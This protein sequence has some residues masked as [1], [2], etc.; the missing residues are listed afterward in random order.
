MRALVIGV[1]GGIGGALAAALETAGWHVSATS[2]RGTP[3]S[4]PLDLSDLDGIAALPAADVC[5]ICAAATRQA[6]C[7]ADEAMSRTVNYEAPAR[8]AEAVVQAGGQP[9]LLSTSAVFDGTVPRR[10]ADAPTCPINTYGKHKAKA[11]RAVLSLPGGT[12][13]RMTK[14][15]MPNLVLF[16]DWIKALRGGR[17]VR[18]FNDLR[19]SPI[20]VDDVVAALR[21]IAERRAEGVFQIS[22]STDITYLDACLHIADRLGASRTLVEAARGAD[23]GMP[24]EDRPANTTMDSRRLEALIPWT[25]PTPFEVLDVVFGLNSSRA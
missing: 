14:V 8:I 17:P 7:R 22:G 21:A 2:R 4:L 5:Y 6:D 23:A 13:L 11:E 9:V 19:L 25:P 12:V 10:S 16:A 24:A 3:G 20:A 18:A 15:M 1:D